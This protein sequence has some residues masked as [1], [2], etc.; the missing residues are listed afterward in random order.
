MRAQPA[1]ERPGQQV[2]AGDL[3]DA[4]RE[5]AH[6]GPGE[7]GVGVTQAE[8]TQA[9]PLVGALEVGLYLGGGEERA[10]VLGG[11]PL[12][13]GRDERAARVVDA[14]RGRGRLGAHAGGGAPGRRGVLPHGRLRPRDHGRGAQGR[15]QVLRARVR[16]EA[17]AREELRQHD[18]R[19]RV[20]PV[21][22]EERPLEHHA[23]ARGAQ[24]REEGVARGAQGVRAPLDPIG[25][26]QRRGHVVGDGNRGLRG[27]LAEEDQRVDGAGRE[28][29][30]GG[31]GHDPRRA[32][33]SRDRALEAHRG[34]LGLE[35]GLGDGDKLR[36]GDGARL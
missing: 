11:D 21:G 10:G 26:E 7:A 5:G 27:G 18:G 32:R 8:A 3:E 17:V 16:R 14:A 22:A 6:L 4:V 31:R 12:G 28:R 33:R 15:S 2:A 29:R 19:V 30:R 25:L 23:A 9:E 34:G 20:A 1:L 36:E 35:R 24:G 13:R